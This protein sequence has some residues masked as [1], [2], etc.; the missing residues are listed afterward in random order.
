MTAANALM[1]AIHARLTGDAGLMTLLG[2][3]GIHDRLLPRPVLPAIVFG[4]IETRDF[5]TSTEKAEEHV[6][7]LEIWSQG[8]GR[9]RAQELAARVTV[10]LDDA[11][12][13]VEGAVL[14]NLLRMST[15]SRR[16]PKTKFY[17]CELRFRA[18]TE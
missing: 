5:S 9:R 7:T 11:V 15:R 1:T 4:E 14:V 13:A 10:L 3:G 17:L 2:P 12:L 18:V 8:E 16:E 6:L